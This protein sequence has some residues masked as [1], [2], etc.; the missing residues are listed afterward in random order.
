MEKVGSE[1]NRFYLS[2]KLIGVVAAFIAAASMLVVL[3]NFS[4]NMIAA[5]TDYL[6]LLSK[7]GQLHYQA[8]SAIESYGHSGDISEYRKFRALQKK[9][10]T[11]EQAV[12][13]LFTEEPDVQVIFNAFPPDIV[14]PNEISSLIFAFKQ[15]KSFDK[16]KEIQAAWQEVSRI[17]EEQL[18][19]AEKISQ[20]WEKKKTDQSR[21]DQYLISYNEL[22]SNWD[23]HNQ[24]LMRRVGLASTIIKRT[25]LWI[26]VLLGIL[27]VLIGVVF[28]VRARKSIGRWEQTLN[29]KEV[30]LSEIHHRVK[31]NMAVVSGLLELENMQGGDPEQALQDSQDRIQSM[32]MIHEELYQSDSFSRVNLSHYLK[33]LTSYIVDVHIQDDVDISLKTYFEEVTLNINQ[34]VPLGLIVNEML[35]NAVKYG[36]NPSC[37]GDITVSLSERDELV[38]LS[39]KDNGPG[40]PEEVSY[41]RADSSGMVIVKTLVQQLEGEVTLQDKEGVYFELKFQKSDAAGAGNANL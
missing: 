37:D 17:E 21:I 33:K 3:T 28:T 10:N 9:Q 15:F 34:A 24:Q 13:E 32:A 39:I 4:I 20:E 22:S 14:Y 1:D 38:T 25:G 18:Q 35:A 12:D 11:Y 16:I 5:S 2:R 23:I 30:L 36:C 29:E 26:S 41:E 8:N 40:L 6:T 19:L 31:N 27:L 7:W